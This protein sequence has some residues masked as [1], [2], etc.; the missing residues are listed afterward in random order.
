MI[1]AISREVPR[2]KINL[3][4]AEQELGESIRVV[5]GNSWYSMAF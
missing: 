1:L 3:P 2:G 5:Q 4:E